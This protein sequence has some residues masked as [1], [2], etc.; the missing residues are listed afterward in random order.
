MAAHTCS[1]LEPKSSPRPY[2][3]WIEHLQ[4]CL[5]LNANIHVEQREKLTYPPRVVFS[6]GRIHGFED[7]VHQISEVEKRKTESF[8]DEE[9]GG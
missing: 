7:F 6:V 3:T 8:G 9:E 2:S 5:E 1:K 4:D